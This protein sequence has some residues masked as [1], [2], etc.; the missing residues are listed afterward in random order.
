MP[1]HGVQNLHRLQKINNIILGLCDLFI[2][3]KLPQ[4][5]HFFSTQ[6]AELN[7]VFVD[8]SG[9]LCVST[10]PCQTCLGYGPA[11]SDPALGW[12]FGH[13]AHSP[14]K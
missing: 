6:E 12:S 4:T 1:V 14:V 9:E 10:S 2:G 7:F 11:V 13:F 5:T 3:N 8:A